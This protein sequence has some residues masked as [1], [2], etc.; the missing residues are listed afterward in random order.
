MSKNIHLLHHLHHFSIICIFIIFSILSVFIIYFIN[1]FTILSIFFIFPFF[2]SSHATVNIIIFSLSTDSQRM[3]QGEVLLAERT[4]TRSAN[5][6]SLSE[7]LLAQRSF[8]R[9]AKFYSLSELIFNF[10][11]SAAIFIVLIHCFLSTNLL[12]FSYLK[13]LAILITDSK[14]LLIRS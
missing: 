14:T 1:T 4:F 8:T 5:F 9:S 11:F 10:S 12:Y 3:L 6:Y 13:S 2:S 7:L